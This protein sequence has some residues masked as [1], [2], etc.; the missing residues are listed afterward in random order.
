M[1][2]L[3]YSLHHYARVFELVVELEKLLVVEVGF[4]FG[5]VVVVDSQSPSPLRWMVCSDFVEY[6]R[7]CWRRYSERVALVEAG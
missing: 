6:A 2:H 7:Y 5:S 3:R 4:E 1:S